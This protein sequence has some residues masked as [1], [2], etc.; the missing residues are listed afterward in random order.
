MFGGGLTWFYR[1]LAG[2]EAAEDAPGYRR[3]VIRPQPAGDALRASYAT[4]TPYGEVSAA[5]EKKDGTFTLNAV[6][7]VG[8][9][10]R[11]TLPAA[12][13]GKVTESGQPLA[14]ATGVKVIGPVNAGLVVEVGSGTYAFRAF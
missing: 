2:V 8:T 4:R 13:A 14:E 1:R 12:G 7:P 5:W 11:V 9:T 10:A 6:V 3:I